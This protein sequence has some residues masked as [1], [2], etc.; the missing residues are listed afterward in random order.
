M[1]ILIM[2][3]SAIGDVI[4]TLPALYLLKN[5]LQTA[6]IPC[7][8]TWVVQKKA[9]SL[10][11]NQPFIDNVVVLPD[12]F[13]WPKN[14]GQTYSIIQK[15]RKN[16]WDAIIDFQ[17]ILKTSTLLSFLSG[18]KYGF[19]TNH[20]RSNI[21]TL[22]TKKHV[23]P[24]YKNIIQKNLALTSYVAQDLANIQS[25]LSTPELHK[26]IHFFIPENNKSL[27]NNWLEKNKNT[28]NFS[29]RYIM[30]AP[31]TTWESKHWPYDYWQK[32]IQKLTHSQEL[33]EQNISCVL[34]GSQFGNQARDLA[35]FITQ[36]N[37]PVLITPKWD[38]Q[39]L[40]YFIQKVSL[41]IA[42]DT[43]LLHL[44]DFLGTTTI[45]IF[46]PTH[47]SK[48]GPFLTQKNIQNAFQ[49]T[50][51]H[52]Y[53]KSHNEQPCMHKLTPE[54]LLSRIVENIRIL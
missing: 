50:C 20:A 11:A 8:I 4:H 41:L 6:N 19:A 15:L 2:R 29:T 1:K 38:L 17:G 49:I 14:W 13:L 32:L 43:G 31:N 25:H 26:H 34:T 10:L 42:P 47:A 53:A 51:P 33:Q 52:V 24:V 5:S 40:A 39:T 21:T 28:E 37:L 12:K 23:T 35:Q 30:L 36:Q 46:G 48:H 18:I 22:F 16:T 9:A 27:V 3:V 44:A 7:T 54:M 45:G